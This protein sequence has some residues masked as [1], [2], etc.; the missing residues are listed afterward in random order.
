[1]RNFLFR[2]LFS[3]KKNQIDVSESSDTPVWMRD[4]LIDNIVC[5]CVRIISQDI[6]IVRFKEI[7]R[8][9]ASS[10]KFAKSRHVRQFCR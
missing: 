5:V 2:L 4:G 10:C 8:F 3:R 1:M 9:K 6:C 7:F